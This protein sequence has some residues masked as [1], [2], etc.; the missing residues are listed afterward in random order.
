MKLNL[1]VLVA[2]GTAVC[3]LTHILKVKNRVQCFSM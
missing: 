1:H 2:D 3:N